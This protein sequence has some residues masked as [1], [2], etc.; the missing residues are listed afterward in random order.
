MKN[1]TLTKDDLIATGYGFGT[2]KTLITE[3]KRLMVERGY[4]YYTNSRL[5]RVPRYIMEQLL[6]CDLPTPELP[7]SDSEDNRQT[8]ANPILTKYDLLALGYGTG[9]VSAL[10]AQAKQDLVDEGFD[11]YAIP[12]LGSVPSSSLENI[13][14]FRPPA[15]PQARQ[16][17]RQELEARSLSCHNAK[18][19]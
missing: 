1:P 12:N 6:G 4:D 16:I 17:L 15:L 9:Q 2:A 18:T 11:Y 13:L 3:S 10:L 19:Q 14:G 8:V 5:G 7:H